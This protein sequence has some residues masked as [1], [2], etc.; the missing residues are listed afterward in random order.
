MLLLQW[1][2]PWRILLHIC[3][4]FCRTPAIYNEEHSEDGHSS[5]RNI[6]LVTIKEIRNNLIKVHF[7][8]LA[9]VIDK[10]IKLTKNV[11]ILYISTKN[12]YS[13]NLSQ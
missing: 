13:R 2:K 7:V 12:F 3:C 6:L 9:S 1:T 11:C 5:D 8:V 4:D 10:C